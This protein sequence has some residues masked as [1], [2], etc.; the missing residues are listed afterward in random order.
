LSGTSV[1]ANLNNANVFT[2][3]TSGNTTIAFSNFP[4]E[5]DGTTNT[6]ATAKVILTKGA[7]SHTVT[8]TGVTLP[9][10]ISGDDSTAFTFPARKSVFVFEVFSV[11]GGTTKYMSNPRQLII[12][13]HPTLDP[14]G[15]SDSELESKI[16][17]VIIKINQSGRMLNRDVTKQLMAINNS[18]MLEKERRKMIA[19][20][21]KREDGDS[22][23]FNDLINVD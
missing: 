19:D 13:F 12:M 3:T 6:Y 16:K 21:K 22:D 1:T 10:D 2:I 14:R 11:D 4:K 23:Q 17:E 15:M 8:L 18:L 9:M 5:D 20:K 7:G